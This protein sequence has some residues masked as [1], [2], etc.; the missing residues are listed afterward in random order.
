[1]E[2]RDARLRAWQ[3]HAGSAVASS[4]APW[5]G[6]LFVGDNEGQVHAFDAENGEPIWTFVCGDS[7]TAPVAAS[8]GVVYFGSHDGCLY[9]LPWHLG[10]WDSAARFCEKK[11]REMDAACLHALAGDTEAAASLLK[12][13]DEHEL[14]ARLLEHDERPTEAAMAYREA[15]AEQEKRAQ[16]K[17]ERKGAGLLYTRAAY[18]FTK[19]KDWNAAMY[20][21][22]RAAVNCELPLL[23]VECKPR[24]QLREGT[25]GLL[26]LRITNIGRSS[27]HDIEIT[28]QSE[29]LRQSVPESLCELPP[30]TDPRSLPLSIFPVEGGNPSLEISV[31]YHDKERRSFR[32]RCEIWPWVEP[33]MERPPDIHI[34]KQFLPGTKVSVTSVEGD[35]V[36]IGRGEHSTS[37]SRLIYEE[38]KVDGDAILI[39]RSTD[40]QTRAHGRSPSQGGSPPADEPQICTRCGQEN[41]PNQRTCSNCGCEL[42]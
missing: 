2:V 27:A 32:G 22:H 4:P 17:Q 21:R 20:C 23:E 34:D 8:E 40:V 41:A 29:A 3:Y 37:A 10:Q 31:L 19:L 36:I 1:V 7:V 28:V 5:E 6:L 25:K 9:A 13:Q 35:G 16:T 39:D 38:T 24:S 14:A 33:K 11:G 26:E 42:K 30:S 12:K 15:A 18:L